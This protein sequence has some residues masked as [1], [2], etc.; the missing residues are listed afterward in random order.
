MNQGVHIGGQV[1]VF[2]AGAG[3][4]DH[5]G[6]GEVPG[7]AHHSVGVGVGGGL[8]Q[9]PV[10]GVHVDDRPVSPVVG[11][12]LGQLLVGGIAR[13][14]QG[15]ED[16]HGA[17]AVGRSGAG[18][19]EDGVGGAPAKDVQAVDAGGQGEQPVVLHQHQALLAHL[20]DGLFTAGHR[21]SGQVH[22]GGVEGAGHVGIHGAEA[23]QVDADG[24]Y[25]DHG[26]H[27][28]P[29]NQAP[30]ALFGLPGG[31]QGHDHN[32]QGRKNGI[33]MAAAHL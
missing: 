17:G 6:V 32:H 27:G 21:L 2:A 1:G 23:D 7:L 31:N 20:A 28:V 24:Y 26:Q 10:L 16:A 18:A 12:K 22:L 30:Q 13:V 33:D 25:S 3:D 29:P 15:L 8:G 4:N 11:I 9:G 5:G 14:L 19:A